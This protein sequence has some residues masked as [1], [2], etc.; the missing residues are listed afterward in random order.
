[1]AKKNLS[2]FDQHIEKIAVGLCL[3][4]LIGA[5][6]LSFSGSRFAI[7]GRGPVELAKSLADTT[8]Q[9][10]TSVLSAKPATETKAAEGADPTKALKDWF[11]QSAKGLA[12]VAQV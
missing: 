11:G 12:V 9:A 7:D 4:A 5:A 3:V 1:M 8:E 6:Y 2:F 10:R